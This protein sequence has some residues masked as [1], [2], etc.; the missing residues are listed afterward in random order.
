MLQNA[1]GVEMSASVVAMSGC[2]GDGEPSEEV[3]HD[4]IRPPSVSDAVS[5]GRGVMCREYPYRSRAKRRLARLAL[6]DR[7]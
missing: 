6:V 3:D 7:G 5:S 4:E 2:Q 1:V